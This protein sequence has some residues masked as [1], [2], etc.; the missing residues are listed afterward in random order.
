M[1]RKTGRTLAHSSYAST[2]TTMYRV[3]S[4]PL[5]LPPHDSLT[6]WDA[7][8]ALPSLLASYTPAEWGEKDVHMFVVSHRVL[9]GNTRALFWHLVAAEEI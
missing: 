2:P 5:T 8:N 6:Y 7:R 3:L 1:L 9:E 4:L